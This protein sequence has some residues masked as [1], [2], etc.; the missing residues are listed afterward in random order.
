MFLNLFQVYRQMKDFIDQENIAYYRDKGL[1]IIDPISNGLTGISCQN[2]AILLFPFPFFRTLPAIFA[3]LPYIL[4]FSLTT[5]ALGA[6]STATNACINI[7]VT[8]PFLR[9]QQI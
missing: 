6:Q 7:D 5:N 3:L 2:I 4:Y 8:L 9:Y 1:E